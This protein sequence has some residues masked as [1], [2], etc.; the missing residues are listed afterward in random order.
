M[1]QAVEPHNTV[2][3]VAVPVPEDEIEL[4]GYIHWPHGITEKSPVEKDRT[5]VIMG[6]PHPKLGGD[7][8]NN[9]V[10]CAVNSLANGYY[11]KHKDGRSFNLLDEDIE[12][13]DVRPQES[14][15]QSHVPTSLHN[16]LISQGD[17]I[18]EALSTSYVTLAVN[19]RGV[20][21]SE[22]LP[23]WFGGP[24]VKDIV[25]IVRY[26]ID[27]KGPIKAKNLYLVGYSFS[28]AVSGAALEVLASDAAVMQALRGVCLLSYPYGFMTRYVDCTY[29]RIRSYIT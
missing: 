29:V 24:E 10:G 12:D 9:V 11:Y 19:T 6:H 27:P 23:S 21:F 13:Y 28:A 25:A 1:S 26:A 20:G 8:S 22:G 14:T 5:C 16:E 18:R 4:R 15:L 17:L 2:Q 3:K 7:T